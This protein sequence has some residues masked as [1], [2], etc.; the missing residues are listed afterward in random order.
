MSKKAS[1]ALCGILLLNLASCSLVTRG[2]EEGERPGPEP[3][4]LWKAI[5]FAP[6]GPDFMPGFRRLVTE[7]F[8]PMGMN[9]VIFDMHWHGFRYTCRPEFAKIDFPESRGWT[10]AQAREAAAICRDNGIRVLVGINALTHQKHGPLV[11]AF[12]QFAEGDLG[13]EAEGWCPL[14]PELNGVVYA[15]N[16]FGYEEVD[17]LLYWLIDERCTHPELVAMGFSEEFVERIAGM[18]RGSQFKRRLPVV[19]K[20]SA[21]TVDSD[22]RYSRD[23]GH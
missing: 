17:R 10:K 23:W 22:F 15:V 6:D 2:P 20:V 13:P 14:H 9:A 1:I 16:G 7:A 4:E 12:P 8:V 19:A 5:V 11:K 3:G 21:R 18:V